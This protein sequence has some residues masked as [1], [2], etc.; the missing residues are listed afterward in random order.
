[1]TDLIVIPHGWNIDVANATARYD[2]FFKSIDDVLGVDTIK[3]RFDG[4]LARS[5]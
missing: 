4:P 2:E 1:M 3:H 5:A